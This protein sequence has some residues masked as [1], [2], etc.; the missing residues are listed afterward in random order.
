M[1]I[2]YQ[3]VSPGELD[4][5]ELLGF[6]ERQNHQTTQS[7]EKLAGML[8]RSACVVTARDE[9][10]LVGIARAIT[11]GV[12]GYLTECKLD[13]AYQGPGAVT[14]RDGRIE[15]DALGIG[16]QMAERVLEC[17]R[18]AGVETVHVTAHGTEEDFCFDLGFRKCRGTVAMQLELGVAAAC[19][20]G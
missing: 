10:Q 14:R 20:A 16:R 12:R 6:Y 11:D 5:S 8:E 18:E 19:A 13:P 1:G 17:L 4:L 2:E 9:G 7:L 3:V 15:H